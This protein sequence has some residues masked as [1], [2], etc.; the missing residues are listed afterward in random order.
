MFQDVSPQMS[1][2]D[3]AAQEWHDAKRREDKAK[4]DRLVAE[5]KIVMLFGAKPEGS[6]TVKTDFFKVE[7]TGNVTRSIDDAAFLAIKSQLPK[8]VRDACIKTTY[9][10]RV[11]GIKEL[12]VSNP[13]LYVVLAQCV[14]SKPAK[15]SVKVTRID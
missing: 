6:Q 5:A 11:G 3:I 1:E 7:T 13:D 9:E 10:P 4:E 14:T 12:K 2:R 15:T 8:N